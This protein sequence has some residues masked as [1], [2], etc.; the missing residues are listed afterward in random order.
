MAYAPR[1]QKAH[2]C[3]TGRCWPGRCTLERCLEKTFFLPPPAPAA[4]AGQP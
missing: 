1:L 3:F 4:P 2:T